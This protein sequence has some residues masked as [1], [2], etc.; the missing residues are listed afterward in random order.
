V[1]INPVLA[2]LAQ[3]RMRVAP[4]FARWCELHGVRLCPAAPTDVAKFVADCAALGI[5]RLWP[6]LQEI[7]A[8]HS[9]LGLA[10]PTLGR[11]VAA[12]VSDVAGIEA[13]R[14]W[15]GD[16]KQR[17]K[18]L[19]YDLQLYV[20]AHEAQREKVLRRAQNEAAAARRRL[21]A[22]QPSRGPEIPT[23]RTEGIEADERKGH[24]V[25]PHASAR[26]S[27]Q[28]DPCRHRRHHRCACGGRGKGESGRSVRCDP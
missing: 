28:T 11:V 22:A 2:A 27:N 25:N 5:D 19:P 26:G 4:M 9:S 23:E 20:A 21:A 13:P 10:D 14:S 17:F 1:A 16:R 24:D 15:P 8:M 6:A 7:S 18:S 12:A 3:A